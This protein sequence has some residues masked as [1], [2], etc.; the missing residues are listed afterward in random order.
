[1]RNIRDTAGSTGDMFNFSKGDV[2]GIA[3]VGR[4]GGQNPPVA[5][6]LSRRIMGH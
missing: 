2:P 1:M 3:N 5:S 6:Q 4:R